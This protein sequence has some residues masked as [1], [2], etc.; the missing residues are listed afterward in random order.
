MKCNICENTEIVKKCESRKPIEFICDDCCKK[1][2]S[3]ALCNTN[4]KSFPSENSNAPIM[5]GVELTRVYDGH[6]HLFIQDL[7]LPNIYTQ[8][9]CNVNKCEIN[10]YEPTSIEIEL[11]FT[12]LEKN[13]TFNEEYVKDS[14]KIKENNQESNKNVP[15]FQIY[16]NKNGKSK[17]ID[18]SYCVDDYCYN[19]L[20][21]TSNHFNTWLPF[22]HAKNDYINTKSLPEFESDVTLGRVVKGDWFGG[23]NDTYWGEL[24]L[25]KR[26][27]VNIILEYKFLSIDKNNKTINIPFGL[28]F[29][30]DFIN[31]EHYKINISPNIHINDSSFQYLLTHKTGRKEYLF[32]VPIEGN[33]Q[34]LEHEGFVKHKVINY[35]NQFH[36]D[37]YAIFYHS[38]LLNI[39][40]GF[41]VNSNPSDFPILLG[42]YK[43]MNSLYSGKYSPVTINLINA[44]DIMRNVTIK[45][46]IEGVSRNLT[47]RE[48]VKP[49]EFKN[50]PLTPVLNYEK[51]KT[52]NE[53]TDV[54][55]KISIYENDKRIYTETFVKKV[56]PIENFVFHLQDDGLSFKTYLSQLLACYCTPHIKGIEK[57]ITMASKKVGSIMGTL[58][59]NYN[60]MMSEIKAIYDALSKDITYVSRSFDFKIDSITKSQ[61]ISLPS[62]TLKLKSGNCIDLS[63]LLAS[64]Y[65]ACKFEVELATVPGHAFLAVKVTGIWLYIE[66]TCMGKFSFERAI[67]YGS[68][69][70][71]KYFITHEK[72]KTKESKFVSIKLSRDNGILPFE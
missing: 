45:C 17:I 44:T 12:I 54:N 68:N 50:I 46:Q 24:Y 51:I 1:N 48:N 6:T 21:I 11:E 58:S 31:Y 63:L 55:I 70:F 35:H 66:C 41:I 61:R 57:A 47:I 3:W 15:L 5:S 18:G 43:A 65:E 25:N 72:P 30:F 71:D 32:L 60:T 19:K 20:K 8:Y 38:L 39:E 27:K 42:V 9:Y 67:E 37:R 29:P 7:F 16:S 36:Y 4:C 26:Y 52:I 22:S 28:F 10:V 64:A 14:W 34:I 53:I 56:Y 69:Q 33:E 2:R 49:F 59:N 13:K 62:T 40:K 23:K